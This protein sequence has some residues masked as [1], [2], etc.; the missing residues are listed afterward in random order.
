MG[1]G[2][3]RYG[4]GRPAY[5]PAA[6]SYRSLDIRK[7]VRSDCIKPRNWFGWQWSNE[8]GEQVASVSCA[9]NEYANQ[10]T[11]SYGWWRYDESEREEVNRPILLTSTPCN[12]GG[13]RQW[14]R[15]PSCQRRAAVLFIMGG[16]L[17]CA[18]CGHVSYASQR[19]DAMNRAWIK[20]R[21]LE[22][23]LIDGWAKPKRMHH[24]TF[25]RLRNRVW[26]IEMERD[27]L[28]EIAVAKLAKWLR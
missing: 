11:V 8:A 10:L 27:R 6:G 23:K 26:A 12:Y 15:C 19:G 13:V 4:A 16:A 17:R 25:E 9:V 14:F 22:A 28:F 18:K 24:K 7:M 5:R 20:Q 3:S 2:G 21:K 1:T